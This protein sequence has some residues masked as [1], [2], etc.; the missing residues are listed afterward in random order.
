MAKYINTKDYLN[1]PSSRVPVC[2]CLDLS[3]SMGTIEGGDYYYTGVTKFID[4]EEYNIVEGGTSR[5]DELQEGIDLLFKAIKDDEMAIDAAEIAIVGFDDEARCLLDFN[6]IENQVIPKLQSRGGT[7]MGEG[8]N[9]ALKKLEERKAFYK[10]KGIQYYQPWLVLMTDGVNN[11]SNSELNE[12]IDQTVRLIN[13]RKLTIFPIGIG[14]EADM[15]TLRRF[16]PN[17]KPLRL[18]GLNFKEFFQWLS[19]SIS[20]TSVS[21]PGEKVVLPSYDGWGQLD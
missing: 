15:N 9:L 20:R 2:L 1:N 18:K 3:G 16:S 4:G 8:V 19:Q 14:K 6:H 7:A 17:R 12:A 11:G 13:N 21:N 5:L 10:S